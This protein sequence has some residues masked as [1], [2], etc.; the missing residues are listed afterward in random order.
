MRKLI[1]NLINWL[2]LRRVKLEADKIGEANRNIALIDFY[3][4]EHLN[5]LFQIF[6]QNIITRHLYV[7]NMEEKMYYTGQLRILLQIQ[8][9]A[10]KAYEDNVKK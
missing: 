5:K 10:K 8:A 7:K 4:N 9:M 1:A 3:K 2:L 6:C